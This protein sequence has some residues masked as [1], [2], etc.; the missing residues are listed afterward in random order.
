MQLLAELIAHADLLLSD[1]VLQARQ[2]A[3]KE[4]PTLKAMRVA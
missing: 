1:V 3:E 2:F 4:L